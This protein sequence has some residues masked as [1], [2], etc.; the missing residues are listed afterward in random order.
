MLLDP[1]PASLRRHRYYYYYYYY[2]HN[3]NHYYYYDYYYDYYYL[4]NGGQAY[5]SPE[6]RW[7]R[8]TLR[9]NIISESV[10]LKHCT[11]GIGI[12]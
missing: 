2:Y 9:V 10:G 4:G 8:S 3:T 5:G 1:G 11:Q 7:V 6:H 12:L